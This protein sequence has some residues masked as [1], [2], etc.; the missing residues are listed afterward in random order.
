MV[1]GQFSVAVRGC[2]SGL[3]GKNDRGLDL[4]G[5]LAFI[6]LQQCTEDRCNAKLNL[7]LRGLN[8]AGRWREEPL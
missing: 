3:Q 2:G 8:P 7:T 4:H 1:H 5:L 6:Q